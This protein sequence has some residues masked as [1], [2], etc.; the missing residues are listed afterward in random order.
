M[1]PCPSVKYFHV[2]CPGCGLQRGFVALLKGDIINSIQLYPAL[3][4]LLLLLSI[5]LLQVKYKFVYGKKIILILQITTVF[6]VCVHFLY[7]VAT[8]QIFSI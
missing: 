4:P 5:G 1:L 8:R 3:I 6:L 2:Q 7:K